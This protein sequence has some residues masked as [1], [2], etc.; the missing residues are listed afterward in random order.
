MSQNKK[1][2]VLYYCSKTRESLRDEWSPGVE[3][4]DRTLY[5]DLEKHP[6][7]SYVG[8]VNVAQSKRNREMGIYPAIRP[9][10][11]LDMRE[12]FVFV[13]K[14]YRFKQGQVSSSIG[15]KCWPTMVFL[16]DDGVSPDGGHFLVLD[17]DNDTDVRT[18]LKEFIKDCERACGYAA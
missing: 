18:K 2:Y 7:I 15:E 14:N 1:I 6:C 10:R 11:G 3:S 9:M 16:S 8:A 13:N 17:R 12:A 5:Y 4:A